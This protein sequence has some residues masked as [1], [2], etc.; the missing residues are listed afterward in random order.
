MNK[1]ALSLL[2]IIIS[3][4]ILALVIT[5]LINVLVAA[6]GFIQ[7]T[8]YRVGAGE[9]GK[10]FVDPLQGYV[11]E[12]TW[13]SNYLGNAENPPQASDPTG[14]YTADYEISVPSSN[15][16]MRKVTVTLNWTDPK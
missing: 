8:R 3:T 4:L 16:E 12:D 2:E 15:P 9:I 1:K 11:R 7:H 14:F 10:E 6:K 13:G 5:G